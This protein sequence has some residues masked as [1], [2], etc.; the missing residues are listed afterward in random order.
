LP[1]THYVAI[2]DRPSEANFFAQSAPETGLPV[3]G[4]GQGDRL[5]IL[6]IGGR[7][8]VKSDIVFIDRAY[9]ANL[10]AITAGSAFVWV[11]IAGL[12]L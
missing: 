11:Y 9:R 6:D 5:G 3:D 8:A 4:I 12:V 1:K 10:T 7:P 2:I